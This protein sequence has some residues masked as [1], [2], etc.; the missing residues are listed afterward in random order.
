MGEIAVKLGW[1]LLSRL[2]T[3]TFLAKTLVYCLHSISKSTSND[4]DDKIVKAVAEALG[5]RYELS[6]S[7]PAPPADK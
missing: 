1:A 6:A 5:V 3:E 7:E 4:L 2:L